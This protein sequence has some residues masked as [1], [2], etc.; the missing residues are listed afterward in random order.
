MIDLKLLLTKTNHV[1]CFN[2]VLIIGLNNQVNMW[3]FT[4]T[5][6]FLYMLSFEIQK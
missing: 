2:N 3:F 1:I 6:W 4:Q 5:L